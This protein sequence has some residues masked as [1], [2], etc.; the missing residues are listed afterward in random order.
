MVF[1]FQRKSPL[2]AEFRMSWNSTFR[3]SERNGIPQK[4]FLKCH[5]CVFP[6]NFI[7][8]KKLRSFECFLFY[9][10]VLNGFPRILSFRRMVWNKITKFWVFF[11]SMDFFGTEFRA[12]YLPR[13]GSELYSEHFRS[14]LW[15]KQN[16][17]GMNQNFLLFCSLRN[18]SFLEKWQPYWGRIT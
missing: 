6:T 15:N 17:D 11:V 4:M 3:D 7:F 9:K 10:I 18:I 8:G 12:F 13:N 16:S 1:I 5:P 2:F 14:V